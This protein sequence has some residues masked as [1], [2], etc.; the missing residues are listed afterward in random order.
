MNFIPVAKFYRKPALILN[1]GHLI[2]IK[3]DKGDKHELSKS[4]D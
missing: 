4:L 2:G 1:A 3:P